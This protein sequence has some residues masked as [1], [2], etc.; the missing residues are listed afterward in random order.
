MTDPMAL[1]GY[2]RPDVQRPLIFLPACINVTHELL[3]PKLLTDY[4]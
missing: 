3:A 4:N 1:S 2:G